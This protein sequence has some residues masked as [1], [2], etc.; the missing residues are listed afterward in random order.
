MEDSSQ[1]RMSVSR[2]SKLPVP[3]PTSGIPKPTSSLP[4][5]TSVIR[6]S[7]SRESLGGGE[8]RNPKLRPSMSRDQ[9]RTTQPDLQQRAQ[10]LRPTASRDQLVA[11]RSRQT[12]MINRPPSHISPAKP[13]QRI[14]SAAYRPVDREADILEERSTTPEFDPPGGAVGQFEGTIFPRQLTLTRRPS[15]SFA[16]SPLYD[17]PDNIFNPNHTRPRTASTD[18]DDR[19]DTLSASSRR[20]RPSLS[21]RTIETLANSSPALRKTSNFF[22]PN[23]TGPRSRAD[24]GASRPG[25][26][27]ASDGSL[28]LSRPGSSSGQSDHG[29]PNFRSSANS[30]KAPL[31]PIDGT[32]RKRSGTVIRTTPNTRAG[33]S[34]PPPFADARSP[35]PGKTAVPTPMSAPKPLAIRPASAK[36]PTKSVF[37]KPS[38][39][40]LNKA[41]LHASS[42][43]RGSVN[44]ASTASWDGTIPSS[45]TSVT[46]ESA[47]PGTPPSARK[48][49]AALREQIAKAKAA[50]RAQMKQAAELAQTQEGEE[51]PIIPEDTGFDFGVNNDDPFNLR[52]GED[53]KKKVLQNRVSAARTSGRLN[54]AALHLKEIPIEVLKMYDLESIGTFDGSWA[55]SVDLTRLVAAD[56]EL[57]E[58]DDFVFP[59]SEP[60]SFDE[61]QASQGNIFAGLETLDMHGNLLVNVPLGMRRLTCLTSL[62]LSSNRL[63]NNS[64]D[65]ISQVTSL[66]DL[67]LAN[68][69]FYGPLNPVL[70]GLSE[71]EI[72]DI[73]GNNISALPPKI[74]NMSRLRIL[75][76]SEN[77]FESLPFD[78]LAT[79]SITELNVRKNKLKGTLIEERIGCLPQLHTLDASANQLE[80]LIPLGAAIDF[81]VLHSL[82]LS[83]NRLQGLPDMT[84]WVSLLTLS[85]EENSISGIPNS[86]MSLEKLRHADFSSNDIRVIPPEVSRMD[87]LTMIRLS[88]NPL[89]D[90]KFLSI[91][92]EDLKAVL[93]NRLDPPP[94]YQEPVDQVGILDVLKDAKD[95]DTKPAYDEE[96][97]Q[98]NDSFATPPTSPNRS[99]SHTVSSRRSRSHTLSNQT[100]PVKPGGILDRSQ[101]ESSSLHP[102]V[103]AKVAAENRVRQIF[104]QNNLFATLPNSLSF[105]SETL[106]AL[107]LSHNQLVGEAYLTEELEL[108]ALREINLASN[109]I[110][111]LRALTQF[112]HA[113]SLEKID[114]TMNRI[115][116][117]PTDLKEAFPNLNVLLASNNHI[118]NLEPE[119]IKGITT[120]DVSNN[121]ISFL[122]PRIGLLGGPGPGGLQRFEVTGN[123]FRVPRWNVLERGT[124]A[125][126]RWLRGRVP[127]AEM[128]AWQGEENEP[129][130]D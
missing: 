44:S 40:A 71:L 19:S 51:A 12:S 45:A 123:R 27:Y 79:L 119:M 107:S 77:S 111:N 13:P 70:A 59:D 99:R 108:L 58:L 5:P 118:A 39:P 10:R 98:S 3:R 47:E 20:S 54:I 14:T 62:N 56:N 18:E 96:D 83:M 64:L 25:S 34:K 84:S 29:F 97:Y 52:Q 35:S 72:L 41:S 24:S 127:V 88:G 46:G 33:A 32:P 100:W 38:L 63:T 23:M 53:P 125:T 66:R 85:V 57:E 116:A 121:D 94:P 74:E 6:A 81:P 87:N 73:H 50:K 65:T 67:R 114:V 89:R 48:S 21:Q 128:G 15:E 120:V 7:P 60:S 109:H 55:E 1:K 26:S 30:F 124:D 17:P 93:A 110:T 115:N 101:T 105:F 4:R 91:T 75:N 113:P 106:T 78:S 11:P 129:D 49:S 117:L 126:L 102:V 42:P 28:R 95:S 69:L 76:L 112:L 31:E 86:F 90:K 130:V 9:L 80:R 104:L 8:L 61:A 36:P 103:C 16:V 68:N 22:D 82:S 92:T 2:P 122:N 37:K 43:R